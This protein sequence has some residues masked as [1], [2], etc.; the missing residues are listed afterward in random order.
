MTEVIP[1]RELRNRSSEVLRAVEN[2]ATFEISNHGRVV[3]VLA[4]AGRAAGERLRVRRAVQRGGFGALPR[5][6][7]ERPV[8]ESLD[9]LR[10]VR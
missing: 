5:T 1:H 8:A 6:R 3:A 10:G 4:P 9:D 2:G 7:L